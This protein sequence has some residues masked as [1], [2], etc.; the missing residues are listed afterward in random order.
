MRKAGGAEEEAKKEVCGRS[1]TCDF[2]LHFNTFFL[3]FLPSSAPE[4]DPAAEQAKLSLPRSELDG[5]FSPHG[6]FVL[7]LHFSRG[8]E[9]KEEE[10]EGLPHRA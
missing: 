1:F 8:D 10:E 4:S 9:T 6:K 5:V 2:H 3:E 7:T